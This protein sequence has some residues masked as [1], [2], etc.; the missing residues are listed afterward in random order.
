M[1]LKLCFRV[2]ANIDNVSVDSNMNV[3][4]RDSDGND[5]SSIND[6]GVISSQLCGY[7]NS[8]WASMWY[9]MEKKLE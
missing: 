4:N 3:A 1:L 9:V 6:D 5:N 2:W 8:S 7:S